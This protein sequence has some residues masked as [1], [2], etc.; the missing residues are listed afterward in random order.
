[1]SINYVMKSKYI[2][3][4]VFV[5]G[6]V[7]SYGQNDFPYHKLLN[8]S[9]TDF[10]EAKFR[11]DSYYNTWT[12]TK[13]NGMNVAGNVL[14]ALTDQAADIRPAEGDYQIIVQMGEG[15]AIAN[16]QVLFYQTG[17]YH[18]I[19]T[20]MADNGSNNLETNS[21]TMTKHQF[22]YG[23]YS[24]SVV[25][26]LKEV[27]TTYTNTYAAAKTKDNSYNEYLYTIYTGVAAESLYLNQQAKKQAKRDAKGKKQNNV[28]NFY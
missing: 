2:F 28:D 8:Y 5:F 12:L 1:M 11:Y 4:L 15:N 23:E 18:D 3:L 10:K 9:A 27:K 24:F 17:T 13:R 26:T 16:I 25:R 22:S 7:L 21:G 6:T 19:L 20:F 14:S